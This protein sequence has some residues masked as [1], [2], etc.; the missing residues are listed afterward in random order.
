[1]RTYFVYMMT[2]KKRGTLYIGV[3]NNLPRRVYE[4]KKGILGGF[5]KKY[6]LRKLIWYEVTDSIR[7]AIEEEKR[8]KKWKRQYKINVVEEENPNW[9]DLS[10][11]F[12]DS[13][14]L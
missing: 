14:L 7:I 4:H 13:E 6:N 10:E 5:T 2:N 3:T 8:M 9:N 1:M 11:E 12:L